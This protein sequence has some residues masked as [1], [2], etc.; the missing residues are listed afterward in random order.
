MRK[1]ILTKLALLMCLSAC[2]TPRFHRADVAG[3]FDEYRDKNIA[4]ASARQDHTALHIDTVETADGVKIST[5]YQHY[6]TA[7]LVKR[8]VALSDLQFVQSGDPIRGTSSGQL[9]LVSPLQAL[10]AVLYDASYRMI[11]DGNLLQI[12]FDPGLTFRH[13]QADED[14]IASHE[15]SFTNLKSTKIAFAIR[16]MAERYDVILT[17]NT[18]HNSLVFS[19]P[20]ASVKRVGAAAKSMDFE[21]DHILIEALIVEF[22]L[23]RIKDIGSELN[24]GQ[25]AGFSDV[26]FNLINNEGRTLAFNFDDTFDASGTS[27]GLALEFLISTNAAHV[28]SRPFIS[29]VS[30]EAATLEISED[31]FVET[32]VQDIAELNEVSSGVTINVTPTS[33]SNGQIA[34]EYEMSESRFA[35]TEEGGDLRRSKNSAISSAIVPDGLTLVVG[36]LSLKTRAQTQAGFPLSVNVPG[37]SSLVSHDANRYQ[38]TEVMMFITPRLWQPG[39]DIPVPTEDAIRDHAK[40]IDESDSIDLD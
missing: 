1:H 25:T 22:N 7:E 30:G 18:A 15:V 20:V 10:E 33:L 6:P 34:I 8:L 4:I 37:L 29:T 16:D 32:I 35:A 23:E 14:G 5:A 26:F 38:D 39:L 2:E 21:S 3:L 11:Q 27:F 36:G 40:I 28:L 24:S 9:N 19:G 12:T 13:L 17:P 31:R